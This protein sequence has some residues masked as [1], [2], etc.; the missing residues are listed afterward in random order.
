M[1]KEVRDK[2]MDILKDRGVEGGAKQMI[3]NK[4][5]KYYL[6]LNSVDVM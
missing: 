5:A 2:V 1:T 3:R 4:K 6:N